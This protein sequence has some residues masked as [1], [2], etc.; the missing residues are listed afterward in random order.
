MLGDVTYKGD[1]ERDKEASHVVVTR[2]RSR[3]G[4][5]E[6]NCKPTRRSG[7]ARKT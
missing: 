6:V 7:G 3:V 1:L 5:H 4:I 2:T